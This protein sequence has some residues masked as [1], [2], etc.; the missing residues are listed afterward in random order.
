MIRSYEYILSELPFVVRRTVRW[1]DCDP[2]GVVYTGRFPEY[3]LGALALFKEHIARA[4]NDDRSFLGKQHGVGLP[5][6]GMSFDFSGTLWPHNEVDIE[7]FVGDIRT[8]TFD[9]HCV[10]R[11]PTGEPVFD[12][13]FSPICVRAD[14]RISTDIPESLRSTLQRFTRLTSEGTEKA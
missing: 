11:R 6:R 13:R 8:R 1:G 2:A 14:A 3:V 9:M 12:A 4:S 7:C 5:C 10:G